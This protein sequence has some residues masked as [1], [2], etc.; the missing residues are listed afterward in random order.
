MLVPDLKPTAVAR[1]TATLRN[2]G[3]LLDPTS[4]LVDVS[5]CAGRPGCGLSLA[6]VR[7][8]ALAVHSSASTA[9]LPVHWSGCD[10]TC[11]RPADRH[12][13]VRAVPGGYQVSL[14]GEGQA[15]VPHAAPRVDLGLS[16]VSGSLGAS[17]SPRSTGLAGDANGGGDG[18]GGG[19]VDRDAAARLARVIEAVRCSA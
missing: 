1:W 11:G 19:D 3:L 5:A 15:L 18:N 6:D 12:V 9:S 16:D 7:G 8:D 17:L 14:D 4:A 10:R 13:Q 2:T